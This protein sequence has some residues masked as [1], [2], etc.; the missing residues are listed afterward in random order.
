MIRSPTLRVRLTT[1]FQMAPSYSFR[2]PP[3][4][5]NVMEYTADADSYIS[6]SSQANC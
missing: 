5:L 6:R 1:F 3:T 4:L 2:Y